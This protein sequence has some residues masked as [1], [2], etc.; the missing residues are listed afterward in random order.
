MSNYYDN[1]QKAIRP[2]M[3]GTDGYRGKYG[4]KITESVVFGLT[5]A[6]IE[7]HE[8]FAGTGESTKKV[9]IGHDNR[10]SSES[11]VAQATTA[12]K[13]RGYEVSFLGVVPT[14]AVQF[15]ALKEDYPLAVMITASH[16]PHYDNG[17]KGFVYGKKLTPEQVQQVSDKY[18]QLYDAG[19]IKEQLVESPVVNSKHLIDEYID[20]LINQ[21]VAEFGYKP[22]AGKSLFL[23]AANGACSSILPEVFARLGAETKSYF[24]DLNGVIN[25][26]CGATDLEGLKRAMCDNQELVSSDGFLG[27]VTIDGDGDRFMG[28]GVKEHDGELK[29][30]EIDGNRVIVFRAKRLIE[31]DERTKAVVGTIYTNPGAVSLIKSMGCDFYYCGNGD[32]SVTNELIARNLRYGSEYSGHHIDITW[33]PSGDGIMAAVWVACYLASSNSTFYEAL[34]QISLWPEY[35]QSIA[36][37]DPT[38]E[39]LKESLAEIADKYRG[40]LGDGA[41]L[42]VMPS[43]TEPKIRIFASSVDQTRIDQVVAKV[44]AEI[45]K[46]I[47]KE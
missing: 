13:S 19:K 3:G 18:W 43:G 45:A 23:D 6:L 17:W 14:P 38:K 1:H 36:C 47:S 34:S 9:V 35:R 11:L 39:G 16:N 8:G 37:S 15:S 29:F 28:I 41:A 26:G 20:A 32:T 44:K 40:D 33:L 12:V 7:V 42:L 27:G 31:Q 24:C 5:L 25:E 22:L 46:A 4:D 10:P 2:L 21:A 30:E